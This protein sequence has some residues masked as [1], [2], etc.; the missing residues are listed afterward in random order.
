MQTVGKLTV[1]PSG[2]EALHNSYYS[3]AS[4]KVYACASEP[5]DP[6]R[7]DGHRAEYTKHT[8]TDGT[9]L[10][11]I[12]RAPVISLTFGYIRLSPPLPG[13]TSRHASYDITYSVA[14]PATTVKPYNHQAQ[15]AY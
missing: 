3:K 8:V 5:G 13:A 1:S 7:R 10:R 12:S 2:I 11:S 9:N 4:V 15:A 6:L 14:S